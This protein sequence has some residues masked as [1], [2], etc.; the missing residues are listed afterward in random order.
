MT[1]E[2]LNNILRELSSKKAFQHIK[3]LS[4][5]GT[6]LAGTK[7]VELAA[8]YIAGVMEEYGLATTLDSF[9]VYN[10]YPGDASLDVIF[11][12]S[13]SLKCRGY[14]HIAPTSPE[15][16]TAELVYVGAG[17]EEDYDGIDATDKI[18]LTD[19]RYGPARPEKARIAVTAGAKGLI[20]ID[21]GSEDH[22]VISNGAMK[23]VWGNPTPEALKEIPEIPAVGITATDGDFLKKL[24]QEQCTLKIRLRATCSKHWQKVSQPVGRISGMTE[25]DKFV[26]VAGHFEAWG[27]GA[28]DNAAGNGLM[29]ELARVL[30]LHRK[31]LKRSILFAFWNGHEIAEASGSTWFVDNYWDMLRDGAVAQINIDQPGLKGTNR[32]QVLS[33]MEL[34]LFA[35][36]IA[37][38]VLNEPTFYNPL[39]GKHSDQSFYG[40]GIP[41]VL[42]G[43]MFSREEIE[44]MNGASLGWWWHTEEDTLD[45]VD[46][47]ILGKSMKVFA[48]YITELCNS[49][50]LPMEFIT[51]ARALLKEL[52]TLNKEIQGI[53]IDIDS[54]VPATERLNF[55]A[56]RLENQ[57]KNIQSKGINRCLMEVGR[58]LIPVL[59]TNKCR[60]EQDSYGRSELQYVLPLSYSLRKLMTMNKRSA[61]YEMLLTE[62]VRE[63]NRISD[64]IQRSVECLERCLGDE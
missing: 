29:L 56:A 41:S 1:T 35:T 37:Q 16:I 26:L 33:T 20:S 60:Y 21:W 62:S 15:G 34:K 13:R 2:L 18:V 42:G 48:A 11:P 46:V 59:Y 25:P 9:S 10:S 28:T 50:L 45:K 47:N 64:F 5:L 49:D 7:A 27:P 43:T 19:L 39:R 38:E 8:N 36:E 61:N 4:S 52:K 53:P 55:L 54:L 14:A 12:I 58:N 40:V 51:P 17:A 32:F 3:Y 6:R 31:E 22:Q 57:K 63:R 24:L 30:A 23:G 44:R